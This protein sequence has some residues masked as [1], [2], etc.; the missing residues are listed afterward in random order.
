MNNQVQFHN[1][2]CIW[3][4]NWLDGELTVRL[5]TQDNIIY[6]EYA[7]YGG[8]E[9]AVI[10]SKEDYIYLDSKQIPRLS[11]DEK[12]YY[13]SGKIRWQAKTPQYFQ[14][15][16][17]SFKESDRYGNTHKMIYARFSNSPAGWK[18]WR[19]NAPFLDLNE[20]P[21]PELK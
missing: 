2:K 10:R 21:I 9:L 4:F 3:T 19:I 20:L 1:S 14:E 18:F 16:I 15:G 13:Y 17:L 7:Y 6:S 12:V 11:K 5:N 8:L